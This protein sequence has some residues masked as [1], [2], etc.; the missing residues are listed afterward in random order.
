MR[1]YARW[2][3]G[4]FL[5]IPVPIT[6]GLHKYASA[7]LSICS[8]RPVAKGA[9]ALWTLIATAVFVRASSGELVTQFDLREAERDAARRQGEAWAHE[10]KNYTG[11]VIRLLARVARD[12]PN[13]HPNI[14]WAL[15][16]SRIL[17]AASYA[18]QL[19]IGQRYRRDIATTGLRR[20]PR[21]TA[22]GI[23][24]AVL[25]YLLNYHDAST[26]D[27]LVLEWCPKWPPENCIRQLSNLLSARECAANRDVDWE[28]LTRAEV[29]WTVALLRE[30]IQNVRVNHP[31]AGDVKVRVSYR[32]DVQGDDLILELEQKQREM[33][34]EEGPEEP[35]GIRHANELFGRASGIGL[36]EIEILRCQ[37]DE[38]EAQAASLSGGVGGWAG[39]TVTYRARARLALDAE[40]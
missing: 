7:V 34:V 12:C 24:E 26:G 4:A 5:S 17:N 23:V 11:P 27:Q 28:V 22:A 31:V 25:Q 3:G 20:L 39:K 36:G 37:V 6:G 2:G 32:L 30:L 38:P 40:E 19:G 15:Q 10:V 21:P 18:I 29:V 13:R 33:T 9:L 35:P 16:G 1:S 14:D 8:E